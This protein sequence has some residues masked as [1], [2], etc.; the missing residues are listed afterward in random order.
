MKHMVQKQVIDLI[1]HMVLVAQRWNKIFED[2]Q[3]LIH[4]REL[5]IRKMCKDKWNGL[6]FDFK[7]LSYYHAKELGTIGGFGK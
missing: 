2:L 6:N 1:T 4:A 3:N 5:R 7:K